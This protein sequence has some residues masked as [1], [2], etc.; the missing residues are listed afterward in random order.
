M[1]IDGNKIAFQSYS[2]NNKYDVFIMDSNGENVVQLTNTPESAGLPCF[3]PDN[4]FI[5]YDQTIGGN[6][7]IFIMNIDGSNQTRLTNIPGADWGPAFIYQ[8]KE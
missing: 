5:A 6:E 8:V 3:S 1:S 7:E 2:G 4:K